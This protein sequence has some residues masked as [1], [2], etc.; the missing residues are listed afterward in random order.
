MSTNLFG[1]VLINY[2]LT[3]A[4]THKTP[5]T[6][7]KLWYWV[8]VYAVRVITVYAIYIVY[9]PPAADTKTFVVGSFLKRWEGR[10]QAQERQR[11]LVAW[12][13]GVWQDGV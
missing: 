3:V 5:F 11:I 12:L 4:V 1:A 6:T 8:V 2:W 13:D 9:H 7:G 10:R